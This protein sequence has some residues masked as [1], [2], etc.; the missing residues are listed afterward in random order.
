M[1]FQVCGADSGNPM[2]FAVS[3]SKENLGLDNMKI[4]EM[5]GEAR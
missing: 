5:K 4:F 2:E 3:M 1:E